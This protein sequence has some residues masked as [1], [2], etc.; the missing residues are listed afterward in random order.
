MRA[1]APALLALLVAV[2]ATVH[3]HLFHAVYEPPDGSHDLQR[4]LDILSLFRVPIF[5]LSKPE[6][7][8]AHGQM[9]EPTTTPES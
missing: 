7:D 2:P 3:A 1:V 4:G 6:L 5:R 9:P 8:A